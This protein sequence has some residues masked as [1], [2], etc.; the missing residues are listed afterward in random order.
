MPEYRYLLKE[1]EPVVGVQINPEGH[2]AV[3]VIVLVGDELTEV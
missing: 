3:D 1:Y 2:E